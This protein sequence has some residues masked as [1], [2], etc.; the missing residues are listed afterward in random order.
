[1]TEAF[2]ALLRGVNVGAANR[3]S[4]AALE[5]VFRQAGAARPETFIQSGNVVFEAPRADGG[6]IV[7]E[8]GIRIARGFGFEAPIVLRDA[9]SW[10]GLIAAN[11][12]LAQGADPK[13]LHAL[14]LS[15]SPDATRLA[16]LDPNRSPPDEF[17]AIGQ[18][19]Y[20]RLPNGV[21]RTKLTNA[22]FDK[23]LGVTTTM[24]NWPTVLGIAALM[25]ARAI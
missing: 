11:P 5:T 10:R 22:W 20:L 1:V 18:T 25:D 8:V 14:C 15:A 24:R 13:T 23:T 12:F 7:A 19:I 3:I 9:E 2:V 21:A 6:A 4:M 17:A 16:R